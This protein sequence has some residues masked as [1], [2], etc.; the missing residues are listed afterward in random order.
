MI[1]DVRGIRQFIPLCQVHRPEC[2]QT[3]EGGVVIARSP[4]F[5]CYSLEPDSDE[6]GFKS[7]RTCS[8]DV[9]AGLLL[10][11]NPGVLPAT[12]PHEADPAE[13]VHRDHAVDYALERSED[14]GGYRVQG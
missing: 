7:R 10:I 14:V 11:A 3:V 8:G 4:V 9:L 6:K 12:H 5:E 1:I 2:G 13:H